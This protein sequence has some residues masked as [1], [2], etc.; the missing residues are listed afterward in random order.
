MAFILLAL[1]A[2]LFI[3]AHVGLT[4]IGVKAA[5]VRRLGDKP[6]MGLYTLV[7]FLTLG[8]AIVTYA[9]FGA[10]GEQLWIPLGWDNPLVYILML[11]S[12]L[13]IVLSTATP[14]PVGAEMAG[15]VM[16][17]ARGILRVTAHPQNWGMIC[18]G[19]AHVLVTG[20]AGGLVLYGAFALLGIVGAYHETAKKAKDR[21]PAVQAFLK[22]TGVIPFSAILR[23]RNRLVIG[24][25]ALPSLLVVLAVFGVSIGVHFLI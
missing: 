15:P 9:F 22:E 20:T 11:L 17:V 12:I 14:S 3:A 2:G 4:I 8:G 21:D 10:R 23:R 25:F 6:F 24:E 5:L 1:F 16:P 19:I 7:S 13:F 18:F